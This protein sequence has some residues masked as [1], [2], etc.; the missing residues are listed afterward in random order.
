MKLGE[1]NSCIFLDVS[2]YVVEETIVETKALITDDLLY[3]CGIPTDDSFSSTC[4]RTGTSDEIVHNNMDS[5]FNI[6]SSEK[7]QG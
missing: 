5:T 1:N 7:S 4:L 6:V 2:T 3:I